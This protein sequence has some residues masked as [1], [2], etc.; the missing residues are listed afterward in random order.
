MMAI[1]DGPYCH[2]RALRC[3]TRTGTNRI[4][5]PSILNCS[6]CVQT[7]PNPKGEDDRRTVVFLLI[8]TEMLVEQE[9]TARDKSE[10]DY[11]FNGESPELV[12]AVHDPHSSH[13]FEIE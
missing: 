2:F 6:P 13:T 12:S 9:Q 7:E 10:P 3:S 1:L 8:E 11:C 5:A 4:H